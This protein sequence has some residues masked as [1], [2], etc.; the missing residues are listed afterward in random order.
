MTLE[1]E[2][3]LKAV[4]Q[5]TLTL[6]VRHLLEN[7]TA[8]V[9][10]WSFQPITGGMGQAVGHAYGIY[11]FRGK[12]HVLDK[13]VSWSLI[14]KAIGGPSEVGTDVPSH[15]A[16]WK[17]EV[18]ACQSGLLDDLR[19]DL[20][21]PRCFGVVEYPGEEFWLWLEDI[22]EAAGAVWSLERYGVAARHLGQFNG[23]YLVGQPLPEA[24]W[25]SKGRVRDWLTWGE[26]MIRDLPRLSQH[27]LAQR[28]FKANSVERILRLWAE[29]ERFLEVLDR[30][31]RSLCHHDAFRR[32]LM[33]RSIS[34]GREQTIAIDWAIVGTGAIGEEIVSLVTISLQFL[35]VDMDKARDL[36]AIVFDGYL[37]GLQDVG[38][39]GDVCRVRFGFAATAAL[40]MGVG[41]AGVWLRGILADEG[42]IAEKVFGYPVD[43]VLD[44]FAL[45]QTY[46]LDLG[47]E[48]RELID[49]WE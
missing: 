44:Q 28:W 4:D 29:R 5:T 2:A 48:A 12:A 14:L 13:T 30:L 25:L 23:A 49:S 24:P 37:T 41:G 20:V 43:Y 34:D 46:L 33:S 31:P 17:R 11:G 8:E 9:I 35:E 1:F 26:P 22:S 36:D 6:L 7:E 39:H 19:G 45:L 38:W 3:R 47:D 16:H 18:L 27:P 40:F 10:D 32:N 42:A 21:A 15:W